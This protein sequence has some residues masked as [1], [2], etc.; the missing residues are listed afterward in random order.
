[1][2]EVPPDRFYEGE[3]AQNEQRDDKAAFARLVTMGVA[4]RMAM[5]VP[6]GMDLLVSAVAMAVVM[7]VAV[8]GTARVIRSVAMTMPVV[9]IMPMVVI[10][11]VVLVVFGPIHRR[12]LPRQLS[13]RPAI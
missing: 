4:T 11:P 3:G 7:I 5:R 8:I 10:M 2:R 12:R 9:M 1:M 13:A 6:V